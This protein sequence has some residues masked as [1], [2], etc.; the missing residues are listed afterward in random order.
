MK[1]IVHYLDQ[2]YEF[3]IDVVA[4][5]LT[6]LVGSIYRYIEENLGLSIEAQIQYNVS[7][8]FS[9]EERAVLKSHLNQPLKNLPYTEPVKIRVLTSEYLKA[10]DEDNLSKLRELPG[11][12]T[13]N[14]KIIIP[15]R[16]V[17]KEVK[18]VKK[19][20]EKESEQSVSIP[21][22]GVMSGNSDT[23]PVKF[24]QKLER[25]QEAKAELLPSY[26]DHLF[27]ADP[28]ISLENTLRFLNMLSTE[29]GERLL[30]SLGRVRQQELGNPGEDRLLEDL[31]VEVDNIRDNQGV[32]PEESEDQLNDR[33]KIALHRIFN[34]VSPNSELY[35]VMIQY[36]GKSL[37]MAFLYGKFPGALN[38]ERFFWGVYDMDFIGQDKIW[39]V[40]DFKD[41]LMLLLLQRLD[42]HQCL[43]K[44]NLEAIC[45]Q[46]KKVP[47]PLYSESPEGILVQD[48]NISKG[49]AKEIELNIILDEMLNYVV[50]L[51]RPEEKKGKFDLELSLPQ[52]EVVG[53]VV[54]LPPRGS[55]LAS[56]QTEAMLQ[57]LQPA[58]SA[59]E[60]EYI[61]MLKEL[62]SDLHK[63]YLKFGQEYIGS[64]RLKFHDLCDVLTAK[65]GGIGDP[66][67]IRKVINMLGPLVKEFKI[68]K[69][70]RD[71]HKI[72]DVH[73]QAFGKLVEYLVA[74]K[75]MD[76]FDI[77]LQSWEKIFPEVDF[78]PNDTEGNI[79]SF[80]AIL[81][82]VLASLAPLSQP[83]APDAPA[84]SR[85]VSQPDN[86]EPPIR[87][88]A[89]PMASFFG[90]P[91]VSDS[92]ERKM[93][94]PP[95]YRPASSLS[96]L[97]QAALEDQ[98]N[99]PE[100]E[101]K[102]NSS[103]ADEK[104]RGHFVDPLTSCDF[105]GN[106]LGLLAE[107]LL[108][109][110]IAEEK[111]AMFISDLTSK[112]IEFFNQTPRLP[113]E[114][115][116]WQ[117]KFLDAVMNLGAGIEWLK[118][119]K[120]LNEKNIEK[121]FQAISFS[122]QF[123]EKF[124]D[125]IHVIIVNI[126]L[127]VGIGLYPDSIN[128]R[129]SQILNPAWQ[130]PLPMT[131]PHHPKNFAQKELAAL[132]NT[133]IVTKIGKRI[134]TGK[135]IES[136]ASGFFDLVKFLPV[137]A[138]QHS[139]LESYFKAAVEELT[140]KILEKP[141][142]TSLQLITLFK[143]K[144]TDLDQIISAVKEGIVQPVAQSSPAAPGC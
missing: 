10:D 107:R 49:S 44:Q 88:S 9:E 72:H 36:L 76:G 133:L 141:D 42:W 25:K 32:W 64:L 131:S 132:F 79:E 74:M 39:Q 97:P 113:L 112:F 43:K 69:N 81:Q 115:Q 143:E 20:K 70:G 67:V 55:F 83:D 94:A 34:A 29:E 47:L 28:G 7:G 106:G 130:S 101:A 111:M 8:G 140:N 73:A 52:A 125:V 66:V 137:E 108:E 51:P 17:L 45:E 92:H 80:K 142:I 46:H 23:P 118:K 13:D 99:M 110:G 37:T 19:E 63:E 89:A 54:P 60:R 11:Y 22:E 48:S 18:E 103:G 65:M 82:G 2:E 85:V 58:L 27:S 129:A 121:L 134:S 68:L 75:A 96:P 136:F 77:L 57:Q 30:A 123:M 40:N 50:S 53:L 4:A 62:D 6:I 15:W 138:E 116:E 122:P 90:A 16:H 114:Q 21:E 61:E 100:K 31:R 117:Q 104:T 139:F 109:A 119:M 135:L 126:S 41:R 12:S 59:E 5:E 102:A 71:G 56:I 128:A 105:A 84:G 33:Y 144:A 38:V 78:D 24:E 95:G 98:K 35:Q 26:A 93:Q 14:L 86:P 3:E 91:S 124:E 120:A 127:E 87:P 1:F